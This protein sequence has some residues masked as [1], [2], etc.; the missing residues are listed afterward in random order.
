MIRKLLV[1][2][3][4]FL[5]FPLTLVALSLTAP[6]SDESLLNYASNHSLPEQFFIY[7]NGHGVINHPVPGFAKKIL[8]TNND[9]NGMP[10]CYISCY[11][12]NK[13]KAIY[14]VSSIAYVYGQIRVPGR[15]KGRMCVPNGYGNKTVGEDK[16]FMDLC[17]DKI[18]TC[19]GNNC[20][21]GSDT[22][23]WYG[24]N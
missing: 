24:I 23:G 22:G 2:G 17:A 11:S 10:G 13:S 16:T 4:L 5:T 8:P 19:K 21:A 15:Y 7:T 6:S 20:W 14:A 18:L 9:Y 1:Y 12:K 3:L